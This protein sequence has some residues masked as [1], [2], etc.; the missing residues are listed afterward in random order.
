MVKASENYA[1]LIWIFT[2]MPARFYSEL[3]GA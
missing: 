3:L 2:L 1:I